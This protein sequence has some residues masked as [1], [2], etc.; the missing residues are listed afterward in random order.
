M[1]PLQQ[2]ALEV[3]LERHQLRAERLRMR[4]GAL[5]DHGQRVGAID[6]WLARAEEVEVGPVEEEDLLL[7]QGCA[8]CCGGG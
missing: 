4:C 2:L 3:R 6:A 1:Y 5:L 7:A 8:R